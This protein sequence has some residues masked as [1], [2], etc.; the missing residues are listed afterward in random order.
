M[1]DDARPPVARDARCFNGGRNGFIDSVE[2]MIARQ[3][4]GDLFTVI[5]KDDEIADKVKQPRLVENAF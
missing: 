4:L 5:F 1:P 3:L 2:L